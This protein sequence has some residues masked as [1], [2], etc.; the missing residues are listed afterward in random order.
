M[1]R[2]I[3]RPLDRL[4]I[5]SARGSVLPSPDGQSH[6]EEA[7]A[8]VNRPAFFVPEVRPAELQ[9]G[10]DREFQF[11]SPF[12][13]EIPANNIVRGRCELA[14]ANWRQRP[15][16][17]LLHGWNAELQY[18]WQF[19]SWS[20]LLARA[21]VNA[22]RFELPYHGSRRP[23]GP[24]VIRNFLSGNLLHFARATHQ[25]LADTRALALWL[26]AQGSPKVGLWGVSLGA[27]LAGLAVTHQPEMHQAVLLTPI[28][29]MDRA[30]RDLEFCEAIRRELQGLNES[31]RA[32]NLINHPLGQPGGRILVVDSKFDLFVPRET[33]DELVAAWRAEL[34]RVP[35]GHISALFS[36]R[37]IRRITRWI[38]DK[39]ESARF[40]TGPA[41]A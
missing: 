37:L 13:S 12:T 1:W 14:G 6:A 35:H 36:R 31:F 23:A 5:R 21:G 34:W 4:A 28:V 25:T 9:F 30:L 41:F 32:F 11:S 3:A 2:L 39:S 16:I 17:I 10:L 19:P 29:R 7:A 22:F 15:S 27:W 8:L 26:R 38:V 40:D 33:I 24:G 20:R 18:K